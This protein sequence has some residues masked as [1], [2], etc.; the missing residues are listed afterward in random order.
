[1]RSRLP[2][3]DGLRALSIGLVILYHCAHTEGFP[4][5]ALL[6]AVARTGVVG[7]QVFFVISGFLITWLLLGEEEKTG[8][9]DL[10]GF[11]YRRALRILPPAFVYLAVVA[12]MAAFRGL[13]VTNR[14]LLA[15]VFFVR[16]LNLGDSAFTKHFWSL[17]IEEQ[18][19]LVWPLLLMWLPRRA[20]L[21]ATAGLI[22]AE[23]LW[24]QLNTWHYGATQ[25]MWT[26]TD[27]RYSGLLVGALLALVLE[28]PQLKAKLDRLLAF[29]PWL[30]A[31]AGATLMGLMHIFPEASSKLLQVDPGLI[32]A[33]LI[34]VMLVVLVE[35]RGGV[36]SSFFELAPIR[37]VGRISYSLYLWQQ[38][39]CFESTGPWFERFPLN[40]LASFALA[41][42]SYYFIEQPVL[43]WR[44]RRRQKPALAPAPGE[45]LP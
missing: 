3:L 21:W 5:I 13:P 36:F 22:C 44:D 37:W 12:V 26:R 19:Y 32:Q 16:N 15:S 2:G 17:S 42:A 34:V 25:V 6:K 30:F 10:K 28:A 41:A 43:R 23:P 45:P 31:V 40:V 14:E 9:I 18:F 39:F 20:R 35:G 4:D 33:L 38:L 1:M 27:L 8:R 7:V 29:G 11:Y 24:R